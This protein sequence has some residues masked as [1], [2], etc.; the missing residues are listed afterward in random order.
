MWK[1]ISESPLTFV[2]VLVVVVVPASVED[3]GDEEDERD[4]AATSELAA[5]RS[6]NASSITCT[7]RLPAQKME[8][9]SGWRRSAI[10]GCFSATRL[11]SLYSRMR[12]LPSI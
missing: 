4:G 10:S 5:M 1:G 9:P 8:V 6:R 11:R 2:L 3:E 12:S 7:P